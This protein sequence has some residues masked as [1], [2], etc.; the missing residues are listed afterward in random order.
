MSLLAEFEAASPEFILGPTLEAMPSLTIELERQYALDP[1]R[2]IAFCWT[3]Y[4][5]IEQFERVL[6]DDRTVDEFDRILDNGDQSLYRVQQS[7]SGVIHAYRRWVSVGGE[8]LDC[9]GSAGRWEVEMRFP[10]QAAFADYHTFL[11]RKDVEFELQRLANGD[12]AVRDGRPNTLTE[13]QREALV[14]AHERGFFEVPRRTTLSTIA[15]AL[16]ISN[17]AVS[18]RLRRG[19]ARLVDEHV[20]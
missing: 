1:D 12:E 15:D 7:D 19:Q 14:L 9:R 20:L 2:P 13:S 8:L 10:D 6:R 17:Q 4:H 11:E 18:E 5:D 3:R 16:D